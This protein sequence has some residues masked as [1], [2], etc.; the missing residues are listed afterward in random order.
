MQY[1]KTQKFVLPIKTWQRPAKDAF[2]DNNYLGRNE[3]L[4]EGYEWA[5]AIGFVRN[6]KTTATQVQESRI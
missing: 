4:I 3:Q 5:V 1:T 2:N 6:T